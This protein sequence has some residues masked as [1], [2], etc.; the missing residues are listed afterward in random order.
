MEGGTFFPAPG[1]RLEA[2]ARG[3][4]P[5]RSD[6]P[7]ARLGGGLFATCRSLLTWTPNYKKSAIPV[8]EI[9]VVVQIPR[10]LIIASLKST[11]QNKRGDRI[12][13]L[14]S[15]LSISNRVIVR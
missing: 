13:F 14:N 3:I 7:E 5:A 15:I 9:G 2:C 8:Q 4:S 10:E 11:K 12:F 1:G 6:V